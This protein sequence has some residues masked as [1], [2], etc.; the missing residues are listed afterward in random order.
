MAYQ[1]IWSPRSRDD[2]RDIVR[3][4]S[5]DDPQRA[6]SFALH[7]MSRADMLQQHPE[8]GR[9]VPERHC[10]HIREIIVRPYRVVYRVNHSRNI[11]EISR[12]WH[13]ARGTPEIPAR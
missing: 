7:I 10:R 12:V 3:F 6:Q 5:R 13:A 8:A 4:I 1:L 9:V 2:L 11:V